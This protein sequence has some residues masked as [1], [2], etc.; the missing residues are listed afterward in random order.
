MPQVQ[1]PR[2][3]RPESAARAERRLSGH[4]RLFENS[5]PSRTGLFAYTRRADEGGFEFARWP[6][7]LSWVSDLGALPRV[8]SRPRRHEIG[9][10]QS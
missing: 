8:T 4:E 1:S 5:P 10:R 7:V 2:A 3:T 9:V 6:G